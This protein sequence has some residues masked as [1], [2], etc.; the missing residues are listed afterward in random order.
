MLA[1]LMAL[2]AGFPLL[3]FSEIQGRKKEEYLGAIQAGAASDYGPMKAIFSRRILRA[4]H[5]VE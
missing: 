3:D 2:Q 4:L 5:S 1:T